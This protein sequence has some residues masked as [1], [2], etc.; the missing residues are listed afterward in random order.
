[1]KVLQI[2]PYFPPHVGGIEYHVKGLTDGLIK[3]GYEVEVAS[4]CGNSS[5]KFVRIPCID[6]LY[7]PVPLMFPQCEADIYHSHVPS[8]TFAFWFKE[9]APH[10]VT[11]HNDVVVPCRVNGHCLPRSL[12]AS[13][14]WVNRKLVGPVLERAEIIIATT[15]SYA[16]TSPVLRD[17][18]HKIEIVPNAVDTALFQ[19]GRVRDHYV[20]YV[21]RLVDYKGIE[22][23][24]L[25]MR[26][27]QD[28]ENLRLVI[29]G[30]GYDRPRFEQIAR[31]MGLKAEFT[32]RVNRNRLINLL[33]RAEMFVLPSS[34]RLE[35]FGIVLLEAMA[36]QTPVLAFDTPGVNEVAR[37]GGMIFSDKTELS[38]LI[39]ELHRDKS[40][41]TVLGELGRKAVGEKYSW[42][43]VLDKVESIYGEVTQCVT[44]P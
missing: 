34:N 26:Q 43:K 29:V 30:D 5:A 14:E 18:L 33:S 8:P 10:V 38:E 27:V 2:S 24:L 28:K 11:Y 44:P 21:G 20:L 3:R 12:G 37:E 36:C 7:F 6:F 13:L 42:T 39:L 9:A 25:A 35:A 17:Y 22:M 19:P 23:L 1:M 40:R 4:S 32:G 16:E 15:K 31:R 41:R